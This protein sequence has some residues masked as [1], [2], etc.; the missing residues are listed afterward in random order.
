MR[1]MGVAPARN[2]RDPKG[3]TSRPVSLQIKRRRGPAPGVRL[4][5]NHE[6][7]EPPAEKFGDGEN[8]V[9]EDLGDPAVPVW[10][11]DP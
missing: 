4:S 1:Q 3:R 9:G 8:D 5:L 11:A 7:S 6:H 10:P 2:C